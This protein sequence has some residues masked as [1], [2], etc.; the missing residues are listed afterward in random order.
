M[1]NNLVDAAATKGDY[2]MNALKDV[3]NRFPE[4]VKEVRGK[5]LMIGIE[6]HKVP[7]NLQSS[8][9]AYFSDSVAD[10]MVNKHYIE[11]NHT[12]NNP[13][14]F[15]F[16]PPLV[17]TKEEMDYALEAFEASVQEVRGKF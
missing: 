13:A 10:L 7:V 15:R 3:Q 17:V 12:I 6:F 11:I 14:V 9:G 5:G 8:L 4:I 16:L 2:M 1:D